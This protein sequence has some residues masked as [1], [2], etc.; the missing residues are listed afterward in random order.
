MGEIQQVKETAAQKEK[1]QAERQAKRQEELE[2]KIEIIQEKADKKRRRESELT[3]EAIKK[4]KHSFDSILED[5]RERK[6]FMGNE[7]GPYVDKLWADGVV[8]FARNE[9]AAIQATTDKAGILRR[10]NTAITGIEKDIE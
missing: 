6:Q 10:L 7:L 3:K 1:E 9:H 2:K 5:V 8:S 4:M